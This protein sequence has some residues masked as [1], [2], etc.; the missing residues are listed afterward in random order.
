MKKNIISTDDDIIDLSNLLK[1]IWDGKI[2]V[3]L[4]TVIIILLGNLYLNRIHR[5]I[6]FLQ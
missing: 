6:M 1:I 4:I 3:I 5:F 2:K